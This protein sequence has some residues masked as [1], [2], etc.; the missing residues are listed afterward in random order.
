M[1][2]EDRRAIILTELNK[3]KSITIKSM[4]EKLSV[5]LETIRKDIKEFEKS[6]LVEQVYGGAILIESQGFQP[7]ALRENTNIAAKNQI[8]ILAAEYVSDGDTIFVDAST[9]CLHF[10][11]CLSKDVSKHVT[12]IT[13]SLFI[14][15]EMSKYSHLTILG[16]GGIVN[17]SSTE[18]IGKIAEE[19]IS[20]L[21]AEK[22]FFSST[23]FDSAQGATSS[24]GLEADIQRKMLSH[25]KTVFYLVDSSKFGRIGYSP[26]CP[27]DHMDYLISDSPLPEEWKKVVI[28][29]GVT[30]ITP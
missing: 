14:M 11:R 29:C 21:H 30:I 3:N 13:N 18:C 4:A 15:S 28:S 6:G 24:R 25:A 5:S 10:M 26:I 1:L 17:T 7:I 12:V 8:G 20:S 22:V 27:V 2:K 19:N 23:G 9:T 16:T